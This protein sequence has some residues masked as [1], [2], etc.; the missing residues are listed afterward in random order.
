LPVLRNQFSG[1]V[2]WSS[3]SQLADKVYLVLMIA[4]ISVAFRQATSIS[5]WVSAIMMAFT[6]Q[7]CCLVLSRVYLWTGGLKGGAGSNKCPARRSGIGN[8]SAAV[9]DSGPDP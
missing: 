4:L 3:F 7:Q 8:P 5:G 9:A 1:S 6:T 2:E